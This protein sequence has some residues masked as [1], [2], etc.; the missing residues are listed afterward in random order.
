M[1]STLNLYSV[2]STLLFLA[3]LE[4][5]MVRK[6][7]GVGRAVYHTLQCHKCPTLVLNEFEYES[8]IRVAVSSNE[9]T[10]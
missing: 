1:K 10:L 9:I 8:A 5:H 3:T 6:G 4:N 2:T 7:A